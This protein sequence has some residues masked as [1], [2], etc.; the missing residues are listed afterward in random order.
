MYK[1]MISDIYMIDN[2]CIFR[3]DR[4]LHA[5]AYSDLDGGRIY[6]LYIYYTLYTHIHID[7]YI[8]YIS[9]RRLNQVN[10]K[11]LSKR[12]TLSL[13]TILPFPYH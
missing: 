9:N 4:K 8:Y 1:H 6:I 2:K 3:A 10:M 11:H 13:S 12:L 5:G 7:I